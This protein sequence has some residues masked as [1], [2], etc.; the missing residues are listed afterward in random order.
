MSTGPAAPLGCLPL[1]GEPPAADEAAPGDDTPPGVVSTAP[2]PP[3][4][5]PWGPGMS[6]LGLPCAGAPP[7]PSSCPVPS[8]PCA[9]APRWVAGTVL[10]HAARAAHATK[11]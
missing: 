7:S 9:A 2:A 4:A 6:R 11:T 8:E 3:E 1:M 5:A 10:P